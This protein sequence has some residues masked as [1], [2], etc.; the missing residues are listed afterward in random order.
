M[1]QILVGGR[2]LQTAGD[3]VTGELVQLD[4]EA[5]YRIRGVDA[6]PPFLMSLVSDSDHWLFVSST[7]ALTAGR[8]DPHHALFPYYT[9]D[10]IHDARHDTGAVTVLLVHTPDGRQLWEPFADRHAGAYAVTRSLYKSAVGTTVRF[11]EVNHDLGLTFAYSWA[12]SER[13]GFVRAAALTNSG[14]AAVTVELLDGVRNLVPAGVDRFFQEHFSTLVDGHKDAELDERTGLGIYTLTSIPGDS[15]KPGEA[16]RAAVA[17]SRGLPQPVH[18]LSTV[19]LDAFRAGRGVTAETHLRGRR[20]AHLSVATLTVGAGDTADW[21]TGVDTGLDAAAVVRLRRLMERSP[22]HVVVA[23]A[24]A[25]V[26]RGTEALRAIVGA[27]DGLQTTGDELSAARH[28][29]NVLFNVMRGGMPDDG[30]TVRARDVAAYLRHASPRTARRRADWLAALPEA[31]THAELV[32]SAAGDPELERLAREF[33][34]LT[35]SRRHGDPSRPWNTFAIAVKDADG[36]RIL[37]YQGNW[38]DIFQNWEALAWSFPEYAESMIFRFVN[39]STADG[40]NPYRIT[41]TGIDW[42]V[43]IPGDPHS[44]VGYWGDHQIIYLLRLL[45]TSQRF[46]PGR[47]RE[48]LTERLFVY[49]D[50]PY[51]IRPYAE[52]LAD[53]RDAV[54]FDAAKHEALAGREAGPFLLDGA[55]DPLRVTLAE[56]LLVPALAKLGAFLPGAG[57]WMNTQR[58]EWNDAN[59][60]LVGYG[61]S[62]VTLYQ[63]RRYLAFCQELL[64]GLDLALTAPVAALLRRT[65]QV[66]T[67]HAPAA[68]V[69]DTERRAILDGLAGAA[70]DYR[71]ALYDGGLPE[72]TDVV[73]AADVAG[74]LSVALRHLDQT[75]A[76]NRRPDG[77]YHSYNLLRVDPGGI[78]VRRL[79]EMLEGQVAV[80]GS[81]ALSPAAAAELLDALRASAMYRPDQNSY[82]LYPDR[83]LPRFL[84]KNVLPADAPARAKLL[85]ELIAR[86]DRRIVVR[87]DDGGLHFAAAHANAGVLAA[88]LDAIAEPDLAELVAADRQAVLDLYEEVFDHRSF[89]GRSGTLY[90]YEGLGCIY[91][92]MV[93]KLLLAVGETLPHATGPV[94]DRLRA[95]YEQIRDGIGV[96]KDPAVH[97]A[98][99]L[100]PYSHTPGFT[101]A[102]QPGMTGQVKED[103][104]GRVAELGLTVTDGRI[105]V[106]PSLIRP[107]EFRAE[108]GT[109]TYVD[110]AGARATVEVPAGG[111]AFTFCQVPVVVQRAGSPELVLT[112][113]AGETVARSELEIDAHTSASVFAREGAV[114]RIDV[115]I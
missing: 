89:T 11:E 6:M 93:S 79:P 30:Y 44:H 47:L 77:L 109:L 66:L 64:A 38:R 8:V 57:I 63:L 17:W 43:L 97:G 107:A 102:Q 24:D 41:A 55:G 94:A 16:L 56:K 85:A 51:R 1:T 22:A 23:A 60:A 32:A 99:P 114:T 59:N 58:P 90:K 5:Y 103:V 12:P 70:S 88:A 68:D 15:A 10:K 78:A 2:P 42:E 106:D 13:F 36:Q 53:P 108:P 84:A 113:R 96:H 91:W 50:V 40:N 7:G 83:Q 104:I 80:L 35:F 29:S 76:A 75:V 92:H 39:A 9:D 45:E 28:F 48:L 74:F 82:T 81:G 100:D 115:R 27:A 95:H 73:P 4:G 86:G 112:T 33:L 21:R 18:L 46:H 25:D 3:P 62:M 87:D 67:A 26:R 49:A 54:T 19:Q 20:G 105:V 69:S 111:Y 14:G 52:L 101:G 72:D 34:P 31:Q 71:A 37:G 110:T 61:V 98:I 65:A